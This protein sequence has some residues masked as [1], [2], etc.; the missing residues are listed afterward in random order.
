MLVERRDRL[1][2]AD[3]IVRGVADFHTRRQIRADFLFHAFSDPVHDRHGIGVARLDDAESH[4][5]LALITREF[6][7]VLEAVFNARNVLE[8]DRRPLAVGHD[9][10]AHVLELVEFGIEL[11]EPLA[12]W[13]AEKAGRLDHMLAPEGIGDIEG[14]SS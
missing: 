7:R 9:H 6:A 11:D 1:A 3:G 8:V 13:A 14:E 5:R 10:L 2:N 12:L 4:G